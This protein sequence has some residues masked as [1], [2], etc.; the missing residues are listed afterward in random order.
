[1]DSN[2]DVEILSILS[3]ASAPVGAK[4][5]A[6]SLKDRGY[7][8]GERA[9]RYHLKVLDENSLTKKLGYSGREITEK[10]IEELEKA[11]I[12]FRIGSVFSQVIE[13][14]Y[15]SDFPSKVL[16]NTAK[17]EGDYKTIK[18]MVLRSFEAGYSVGDYLNIKKKGN[19]VSVET[20]CSITFD[21]FLLKNGIIPTPEYGGIVKFED[22]EPVNFEGVIDFKSS[23]ID[24]LVAFI[25]Q[26]KTDVIGVIE[27]GEGLVPA[28]F[29]VIPKSSEKQFENI[30][31]KDMLNSVLAY[32]TENVLGM[33]LNPEQIGVVLVGGLT[34]L[35]IPHESGYTA[36]ISAATQLK[37]ISSM[38]K[39]TKGFLE[40]KKKKGKFK[41]TPVLSKMLSK[42]QTINYDIEDKKGNVVVNAAKIPIEYK[43]EAI[44]ALKDSYENK[45]AISDRLKVECDDKFLNAYTIC[46]LT[47]DGVFLKNKIPVIP[48]YGG[49][50]EV[51]ADKKRFI[52]AIDYEGTSLDPHEV[53]FNKADGKNYILAGIRKVPMSASEKLIELNEK[54]GWNSIIEIGRPN[55]DICGVRVEKCMFGITTI[56]GTNPFANIRKN[57]IPVEMKTLHKS[58]DYSELT[59]YDDI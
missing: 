58:I 59:H 28:N 11:N 41:V 17:F 22:Y 32:G 25:M 24:P 2:I 10:G 26:G 50:L 4:I 31:K 18:E 43:E 3:E 29:R 15:L 55:N 16:I 5:I 45:L 6:D 48:Y 8:I 7:D 46:S 37:D 57:N 51:K 1:M 13:K 52:E 9:V 33:N 44:N 42:M 34:P 23:S 20:L 47:V 54:L 56:G 53:F 14:L 12:S 39:K 38:E 19:T 27:N 36:D 35:C 21:N 40:A 30:L 49:I